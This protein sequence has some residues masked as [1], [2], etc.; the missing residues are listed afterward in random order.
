ME[1]E[2]FETGVRQFRLAMAMVW[3][4]RIDPRMVRQLIDD[5]RATLTEFG[6]PGVDVQQLTDGPFADTAARREF[7]DSAV[8]RTARRLAKC[9][10]FYAERFQAAG[11]DPR[12]MTAETAATVPVTL[13]ADLLARAAD[14]RCRGVEPALSS[15]T[16]GTTGRPAEIWLSAYEAELWPALAGLSGLLRGEIGPSDCMQIN[17][18]SRATAAVQQDVTLCRLVGARSRVLGLLPPA[19]SLESLLTGAPTML[20]TYPSYLAELIVAARRDG[21]GPD[22]FAL[23]RIDVGGEVLSPAL[24]AAARQILGASV[25]N[26][27]Y[28]MTEVLPVSGRR[29]TLGHLHPD[30]NTGLVEV[31]ALD[32]A[33]PAGPGQLGTLVITPYF[34]YRDCMP[35]FRYDTRDVVRT[36]ADAPDCELAAVPA[37][38][39]VLGKA[40]DILRTAQGPVTPRELIEAWESLPTAPWP[41]RF[42]AETV[43]GRLQLTVPAAAV[44]GYGETAT[45][46]HLA[47]RGLDVDLRVV[48]LDEVGTRSLRPVR[49]DLRETSFTARTPVPAS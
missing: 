30:L 23:H 22:D 7:T 14:F 24:A 45:R 4:R 31:V 18:S 39:A 12:T 48:A 47:D 41:A 44:D 8:R 32:G 3:G 46:R 26:D 20:A 49:A 16:T 27:S 1:D 15:R 38:S 10:P 6:S 29:C 34:P 19:E 21:L 13:K 35:V 17:I 42:R 40:G 5:A 36:L 43:D 33:G 25:V 9:S 11:I 28:G 37:T 2:M